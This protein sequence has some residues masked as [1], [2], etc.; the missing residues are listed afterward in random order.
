MSLV[1]RIGL[2][3]DP[4]LAIVT[5]RRTSGTEQP[6]SLNTYAVQHLDLTGDS[7]RQV[8][9]TTDVIHRYGDGAVALAQAALT[10][11]LAQQQTE[12]PRCGDPDYT[13][14]P[15]CKAPRNRPHTAGCRQP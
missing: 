14:C 12:Q 3:T 8:G 2:N 11:A 7:V 6:D 1:I 13:H 9:D 4:P 5:A 10:A 15:T